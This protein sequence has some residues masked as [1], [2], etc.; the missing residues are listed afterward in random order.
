MLTPGN[1]LYFT[2]FYFPNGNAAKPKYFVVLKTD[3]LNTLVASLPTTQNHIPRGVSLKHGCINIDEYNFNCYVFL[4]NTI[5]TDNSWAFP[6][7]TF[8]Y[9]QQVEIFNKEKFEEIYAIEDIDY[10]LIGKLSKK[11]FEALKKCILSS[12]SVKRVI[13]RMLAS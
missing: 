10:K 13:K 6:F 11:E 7:D 8:V 3:N 1:L 4:K 2:P 12:S 5:V 9:G